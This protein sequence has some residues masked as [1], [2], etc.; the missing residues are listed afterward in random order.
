MFRTFELLYKKLEEGRG[1]IHPSRFHEL[2]YEELVRD[3]LGQMRALY[4][5]L[6]LGGFEEVKPS[7]ERHLESIREYQT[8]QYQLSPE[9]HAQITRR[10]G[11]I[12]QKYGYG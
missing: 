5:H 6:G 10:L 11:W 12:V 3:P 2:R 1:L 9:L 4:N 7:I 8:N